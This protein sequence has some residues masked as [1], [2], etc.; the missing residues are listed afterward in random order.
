MLLT[1]NE[2]P[3][4]F[5]MPTANG[6]ESVLF[7]T[8]HRRAG[9]FILLML[10]SW[11]WDGFDHESFL[12]HDGTCVSHDLLYDLL[13]GHDLVDTPDGLAHILREGPSDVKVLPP[14]AARVD[15]VLVSNDALCLERLHLFFTVGFPIVVVLRTETSQRS[16]GV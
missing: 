5:N 10:K 7:Q 9:C 4:C 11:A 13:G 15:L 16:T 8:L 14:V 6:P 3:N 12:L 1:A 2:P